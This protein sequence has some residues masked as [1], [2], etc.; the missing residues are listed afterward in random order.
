MTPTPLVSNMSVAIMF[1]VFSN[2]SLAKPLNRYPNLVENKSTSENYEIIKLIDG[3]IGSIFYN[4]DK[5]QVIVDAGHHE[6]KIDAQGQLI[7]ALE[8]YGRWNA[9][10]YY[11]SPTYYLDWIGT[12]DKQEKQFTQKIDGN[13]FTDQQLFAR[14]NQADVVEFGM[15]AN[16]AYAYLISKNNS[17]VIDISSKRDQVHYSCDDD[18]FRDLR[19]N[20]TCFDG[21]V[22]PYQ[23]SIHLLESSLHGSREDED[24]L[25]PLTVSGFK[26]RK[27]YF[28]EGLA[29]QLWMPFVLP[30][31]GG[32]LSDMPD[33]YWFGDALIDLQH[34]NETLSFRVFADKQDKDDKNKRII[35]FDNF[36]VYDFP[37]QPD[38]K[39]IKL[40]YLWYRFSGAERNLNDYYED[41]V[42][43]YVLRKKTKASP[44]G[45]YPQPWF[46]HVAG[47]ESK[48]EIWG[49][50]SFTDPSIS[51][52]Y[53]Q[54]G[55]RGKHPDLV[56]HSVAVA[57]RPFYHF[58]ESFTVNVKSKH[59]KSIYKL[60]VSPQ[61]TAWFHNLLDYTDLPLTIRFN[62]QEL[63]SVVDELTKDQSKNKAKV[64][65]TFHVEFSEVSEDSSKIS[66]SVAL[67]N[68][69]KP[70]TK[71]SVEY[72][73][74]STGK[75]ERAKLKLTQE[76]V[77]LDQQ[78]LQSLLAQIQR[79]PKAE[80]FTEKYAP[81]ILQYLAEQINKHNLAGEM[82][83]SLK[84]L[85]FYV[86]NVL[87][88][89]DLNTA[90]QSAVY[91][92]SVIASQT[93]VAAIYSKQDSMAE[94]VFSALL[95]PDFDIT[96]QENAA[97][98]YNLAACY[99]LK[100]KKPELLAASKQARELGKPA[101][102][103]L[104]DSDFERYLHDAEFLDILNRKYD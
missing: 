54:L 58:P 92:H 73:L 47:L 39:I 78:P 101:D 97:L 88:F 102:Q 69:T 79:L 1:S 49:N 63:K 21:Y 72:P 52:Q 18:D 100:E 96:T 104:K 3:Q 36:T 30:F 14:F 41:N 80:E 95:G 71:F 19:W 85:T 9:S 38:V 33:H 6:W 40:S 51:P 42:G 59:Y 24:P 16:N 7:D 12:G 77:L 91:N 90:E 46:I 25:T 45:K 83:E 43:L 53:Y 75:I 81:F 87:P 15:T 2:V 5:Q 70:L 34:N 17:T 11:F 50:I 66:V 98:V 37:D 65:L 28:E 35:N 23:D 4:P 99:A 74:Q 13:A 94:L 44:I 8:G 27:Y 76:A 103:F 31:Y 48:H 32:K 26:K 84:I 93:L 68:K 56:L 60:E 29:A 10:G 67:G 86:D 22:K 82:A 20:K 61:E 89:V 55:E 62:Q 57:P 64:A